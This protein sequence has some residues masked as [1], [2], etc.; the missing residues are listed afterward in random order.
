M[1]L[2]VMFYGLLQLRDNF[3][4]S[5][6]VPLISYH[7]SSVG[8]TLC[9]GQ[10]WLCSGLAGVLG[11]SC[12]GSILTSSVVMLLRREVEFGVLDNG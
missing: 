7:S 8:V 9:C 6:Q 1:L 11:Q 5:C 2:T 12:V 3:P 10:L 4:L